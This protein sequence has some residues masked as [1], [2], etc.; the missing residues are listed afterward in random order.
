MIRI[1]VP[2]DLS[3]TSV[4]AINYA[5][6]LAENIPSEIFLVHCFPEILEEKDLEIPPGTKDIKAIISAKRE[7]E[8]SALENL[9]KEIE[10]KLSANEIN[11]ISIRTH[12]DIGYPEDILLSLSSVLSPDVIVMGTRS[13][14]ET[15]KELLGSVTS[16]IVRK[17]QVPVL[18]VPAD[19]VIKHNDISNILF[20][21]DFSEV[22]YRSLHKLIRLVAPF[23][24]IIYS[25][26]FNTSS[27]DR[28]DKDKM[29]EFRKYCTETY[30][31]HD[32]RAEILYSENFLDT[33]DIF[34]EKNKI[35]IIAMTRKKRNIISS[36]FHPGI[37][38]KILF[39]TNVP[40]L[41]F[42][43]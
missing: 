14:D 37:T 2:V 34:I 25:V 16:D 1:L 11:N 6:R 8:K 9:K 13:K 33:L 26:Q 28:W 22:D 18:T 5:L 24:T 31:N 41:V 30:R 10:D 3:E 19:S 17:A 20:V 12:F 21:T 27:P 38:R 23:K 29:E 42:H 32:I 15:I 35:D 4:K 36:L 40:L 39:H 7:K 43:T